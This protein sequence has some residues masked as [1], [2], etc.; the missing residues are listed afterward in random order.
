MTDAPHP[1]PK[2]PWSH[3]VTVSQLAPETTLTLEPSAETRAALA[4][5]AGALE[6]PE[7]KAT[8]EILA[9]RRGDVEVTGRITGRIIQPCVVTLEPVEGTIDEEVE[10]RFSAHARQDAVEPGAE[11]EI[12]A[13]AEDPPEPIVDGRIDLGAILTEFFSL[14][15]DPYPRKPGVTWTPPQPE[16]DADSPFAALAKLKSP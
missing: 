10:V 3:T 5:H 13:E 2:A 6:V 14:G 16:E 15:I 4:R 1:A 9:D 11:I 7:L 12:S 8:L